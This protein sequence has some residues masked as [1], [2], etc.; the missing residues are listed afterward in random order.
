[1][2]DKRTYSTEGI[3]LARRNIGEA[4]RLLT[5]Y[6]KHYGKLKVVAKGIRR[7]TSRKRGSLELFTQVK[8]FAIKGK[9]FDII[10][11]VEVKDNFNQWRRDLL[12]V[13]VA[14]HLTEVVNRLTQENQE[15]K[16][17]YDLLFTAF[18]RLNDFDRAK[19][20]TYIAAFKKA[21]LT[22]L[23]F[24]NEDRGRTDYDSYIEELIQGRLRTKRFLHSLS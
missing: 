16:K 22:E 21:V 14:Y 20:P 17:V 5:I 13:G 24:L 2:R 3:I 9:T 8:F 6:T 4:D 15:H 18:N 19:L 10:T 1:M 12:R 23:G 11:E 7:T